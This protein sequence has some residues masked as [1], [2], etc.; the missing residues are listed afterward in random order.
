MIFHVRDASIEVLE[1]MQAALYQLVETM[2]AEGPCQAEII[3]LSR[4]TP[5]SMDERF[6]AAIEAAAEHHC[7]GSINAC[8]AG[9]AMTPSS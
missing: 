7:P 2:N 1:A 9:L 5:A 6:L 8:R 3:N 4:S